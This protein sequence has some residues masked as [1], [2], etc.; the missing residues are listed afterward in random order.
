MLKG[1]HAVLRLASCP[2]LLLGIE[3][4]KVGGSNIIRIDLG[5]PLNMISLLPWQKLW[6]RMHIVL[7]RLHRMV[8]N[9]R[10]I[11]NQPDRVNFIIII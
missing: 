3:D 9:G 5:L 2:G 6:T 1:W 10:K 4:V 7:V 11:F 8:L